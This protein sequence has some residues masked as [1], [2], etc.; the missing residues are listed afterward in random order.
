LYSNY[1][2][3]RYHRAAVEP[4]NAFL[5]SKLPPRARVLDLCCGE[6]R[7][8][9]WLAQRGF[10]VTGLDGSE[11]MLTFARQRCPEARFLLAD[12]RNFE[13][14]P[15]FH[16]VVSTFDSLNHVMTTAGLARV[17]E[18]VWQCLRPGGVFVFD[19]NGEEAYR[20]RWVKTGSIVTNDLVSVSRGFYFPEKKLAICNITMM[21]HGSGGWERSD[22]EL[23]Q[24]C[25]PRKTVLARLAAA[26]FET[27]VHEGASI[28]VQGNVGLDRE[29][30]VARKPR[31]R[32]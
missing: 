32:K 17:F 29:F 10:I 22:F 9:A 19:I 23:Y 6:G 20:S 21:L 26:G 25:H 12:A 11:R 2:A 30:Y 8:A 18:C 5:F 28:G 24:R 7:L 4:L 13:L 16:A 1:W 3:E 27:E 14:P 15:N 31:R